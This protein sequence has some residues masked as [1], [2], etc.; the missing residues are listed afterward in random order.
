[1]HKDFLRAYD[2]FKKIN[3]SKKFLMHLNF[4]AKMRIFGGAHIRDI[5]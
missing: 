1:M 4:F 2:F 5:F 3:D